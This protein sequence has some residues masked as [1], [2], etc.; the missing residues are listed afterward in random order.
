MKFWERIS[1]RWCLRGRGGGRESW[2][3]E[4][5][6]RKWAN[7]FSFLQKINTLSLKVLLQMALLVINFLVKFDSHL[8]NFL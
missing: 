8:L 5:D 4:S 6:K 7:L 2:K 3:N 1:E